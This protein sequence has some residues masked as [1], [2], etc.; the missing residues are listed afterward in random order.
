MANET[1][2]TVRGYCA[3]APVKH[4][5]TEGNSVTT[6]RVGVTAHAWNRR[7]NAYTDGDTV[8]YDV[9]CYGSL[10]ENIADCVD[11]GTPLLI[12]GKLVQ[13]T[14]TDDS[15]IFHQKMEI[16]ADSVGIEL[17]NG[18]ARYIKVKRGGSANTFEHAAPSSD[19]VSRED[20]A[21]AHGEPEP[22]ILDGQEDPTGVL[23]AAT[24]EKTL[25][26]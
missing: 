18:T 5:F 25:C 24:V 11:K 22:A 21:A 4:V 2:V 15:D 19:S 3:K 14:W 6:V 10:G 20:L 9:R 7:A 26:S 12:R 16:V 17:G 8:W 23:V 13:R 1:Y